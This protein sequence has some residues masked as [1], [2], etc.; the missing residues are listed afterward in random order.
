[1]W[2]GIFHVPALRMEIP[3]PGLSRRTFPPSNPAE[4][5]GHLILSL[6]YHHLATLSSD[7]SVSSLSV[8]VVSRSSF[9]DQHGWCSGKDLAYLK[10]RSPSKRREGLSDCSGH[11]TP[12]RNMLAQY[13]AS[14]ELPCKAIGKIGVI[15]FML[16]FPHGCL[17]GPA[18]ASWA[19][20]AG[21]G[22]LSLACPRR[23][24]LVLPFG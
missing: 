9:S 16:P 13:G 7:Q 19:E 22:L 21:L 20:P 8:D 18:W 10:T 3:I 6:C 1:M 11:S 2:W 12:R 24:P 23:S 15:C 4:G 5:F 14:T 17:A